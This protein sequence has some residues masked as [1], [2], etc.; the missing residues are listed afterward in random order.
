MSDYIF[1][2]HEEIREFDRLQL[3]ERASDATTVRLLERAGVREESACLEVGPGAG[4]ILRWLGERVGSDGLVVGVDRTTEFLKDFGRRPYRIVQSDI[5]DY[6]TDGRFDVIHVRY[7]LIHNPDPKRILTRLRSLLKPGGYIVAEEPDFEVSE[8]HDEA[9]A[10]PCN[11]VNDAIRTMFLDGGQDP[12]YGKRLPGQI[13]EIGLSLEHTET[14]VHTEPGG[15]LVAEL[16]A[17]STIALMQ[18][19]LDTVKASKDDLD[20]YI[21]GA[22]DARSRATYYATVSVVASDSE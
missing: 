19:Y 22:R 12:G 14:N 20:R 11:R 9:Y 6:T 10:E 1:T 15:G 18:K 5:A 7:V 13:K 3:L 4:S 17:V 16:M 21:R 8:W 2:D